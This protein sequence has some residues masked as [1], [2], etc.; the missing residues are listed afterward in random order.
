MGTQLRITG[1]HG[2]RSNAEREHEIGV[3][4]DRFYEIARRDPVL[5][6]VFERRV[7][8]WGVH[9]A[10]MRDFWSAAIYRTGRYS[11]RPLE[12]HR[13]IPEIRVEHFPRWLRLWRLAVDET[14]VSDAREPL[15]EFASRMS[16]SMSARLGA[17]GPPPGVAGR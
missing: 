12:S 5:G 10:K 17:P 16:V 14:V 4:V 7:S 11:G 6:P 8:D 2:P 3:L 9:L 13:R 1:G 15:K